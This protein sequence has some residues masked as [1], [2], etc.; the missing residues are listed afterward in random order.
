M[1]TR[2]T[3]HHAAT[4]NEDNV[5]YLRQCADKRRELRDKAR[6]RKDAFSQHC[7]RVAKQMTNRV[8]AEELG[9]STQTVEKVTTFLTWRH[10]DN[11][12][13]A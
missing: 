2:G 3:D 4:L 5:R 11:D 13:R 12:V 7:R 9:V 8:L 10:V 1:H 6:G